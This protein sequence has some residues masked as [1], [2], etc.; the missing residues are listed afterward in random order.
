M[1]N[2][3]HKLP[4]QLTLEE[5]RIELMRL[6]KLLKYHNEQYYQKNAPTITDSEYDKLFQRHL[7]IEALFPHLL[8]ADSATQ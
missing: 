6:D 5:A 1:F 7:K 2:N 4:E 3:I 8:A